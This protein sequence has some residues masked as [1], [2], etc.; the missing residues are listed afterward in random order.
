MSA[1][2]IR[3]PE[4]ATNFLPFVKGSHK[5]ALGYSF[6]PNYAHLLVA[7]AAYG[8]YL[9]EYSK[10]PEF[11]ERDPLPIAIEIFKSQN[12]WELCTVMALD[13]LKNVEVVEDPPSI[14]RVVEGLADSGFE[15]MGELLEFA[16]GPEGFK[17]AWREIVLRA[18]MEVQGED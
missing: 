10:D 12:L 1:N 4:S 17:E 3:I 18:A 11:K 7:A 15:G 6:Y 2:A 9:G 14:C 13:H 5:E 8:R 16:G